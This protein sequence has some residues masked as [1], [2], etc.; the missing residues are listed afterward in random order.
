LSRPLATQS[1][2]LFLWNVG[3]DAV[4]F[5]AGTTTGDLFPPSLAWDLLVVLLHCAA[6]GLGIYL[7]LRFFAPVESDMSWRRTI[8]RGIIAS[9]SGTVV[10]FAF[11]VLLTV[12][13]A[14]TFGPHPFGYS[15]SAG[16]DPYDLQNGIQYA[17]KGFFP[18]LI[19]W[20][21]VTALGVVFLRLWLSRVPPIR[22]LLGAAGHAKD[23]ASRVA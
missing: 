15:F 23:R 7:A 11:T 14:T 10:A 8:A 4:G 12:I 2:V 17:I 18:P 13:T 22:P 20:L 9:L 3:V 16:V 5:A 21:P 19:D 6:F 1:L